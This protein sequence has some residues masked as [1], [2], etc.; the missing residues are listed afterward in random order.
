ME[1]L[2]LEVKYSNRTER[3]RKWKG[4]KIA[5]GVSWL[6][7]VQK[8]LAKW[9][10]YLKSRAHSYRKT[11]DQHGKIA[12][13]LGEIDIEDVLKLPLDQMVAYYKIS[14]ADQEMREAVESI[15]YWREQIPKAEDKLLTKYFGKL[16]SKKTRKLLGDSELEVRNDL[17]KKLKEAGCIEIK[18]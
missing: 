4:E 6:D 3:Q 5:S 17:L 1:R 13:D 16:W 11:Y 10:M 18:I 12:E 2:K 15:H 7:S 9:E 8:E 14:E